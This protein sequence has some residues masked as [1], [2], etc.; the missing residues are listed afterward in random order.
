[1]TDVSKS[2][3]RSVSSI[4]VGVVVAVLGHLG[5]G[6]FSAQA[7]AYVAPA[8]AAGYAILVRLIESKVPA[9]GWLLGVPGKPTYAPKPAAVFPISVP[10]AS[11]PTPAPAP[12]P[13]P[14]PAVAEVV[15]PAPKTPAKKAAPAA[16]KA[17]PKAKP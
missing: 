16:K 3:I 6:A 15:P 4:A 9:V 8:V 10:V 14:E 11:E 13:A 7:A 17:A 1:M 2:I 12:A 5:F